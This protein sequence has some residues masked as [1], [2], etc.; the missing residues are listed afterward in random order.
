[1][2]EGALCWEQ[3]VSPAGEANDRVLHAGDERAWAQGDSGW[4]QKQESGL[5]LDLQDVSVSITYGLANCVFLQ[6]HA[7]PY[8]PAI[9]FH[10]KAMQNLCVYIPF[11]KTSSSVTNSKPGRLLV[12]S[13]LQAFK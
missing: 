10:P 8:F 13:L 3:G 4:E 6:A 1:M 9:C 12:H 5:F 11:V 7:I 2:E